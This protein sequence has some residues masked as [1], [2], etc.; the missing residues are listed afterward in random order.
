MLTCLGDDAELGQYPWLVNLG[1]TGLGKLIQRHK[2]QF[3][4]TS[5]NPLLTQNFPWS[6]DQGSHN[7]F[8]MFYAK[9][10]CDRI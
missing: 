9:G 4:D 3:K 2:R 8:E 10:T 5:K 6:L 7:S 1:Y